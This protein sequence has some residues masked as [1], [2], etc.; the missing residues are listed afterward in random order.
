MLFQNKGCTASPAYHD[1]QA[2]CLE[3]QAVGEEN[4]YSEGCLKQWVS[5]EE[6]EY[7]GNHSTS[8][9]PLQSLG[10]NAAA[11]G[12]CATFVPG[13]ILASTDVPDSGFGVNYETAQV[14]S[15][16]SFTTSELEI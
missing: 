5:P 9:A 14:R 11:S 15:A 7:Y 8:P 4:P 12:S 10:G 16:V 1:I 6:L 13:G 2:L 3:I